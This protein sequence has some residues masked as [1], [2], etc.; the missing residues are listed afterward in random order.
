MKLGIILFIVGVIAVTYLAN[1]KFNKK[2][3]K[4]IGIIFAILL[5]L[6]GLIQFLQP[7]DYIKFTKTTISEK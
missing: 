4:K 3:F 7:D 1:V 6:Y 5:S 2:A